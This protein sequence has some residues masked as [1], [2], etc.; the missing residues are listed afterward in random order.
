MCV[1]LAWRV[2][3]AFYPYGKFE[4]CALVVPSWVGG[5]PTEQRSSQELEEQGGDPQC[6]AA[7]QCSSPHVVWLG[8]DG[9][10]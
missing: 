1:Q 5:H 4:R 3:S 10:D 9:V 8:L 2:C 7:R 6:A